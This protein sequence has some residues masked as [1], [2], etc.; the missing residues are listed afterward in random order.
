MQRTAISNSGKRCI[1]LFSVLIVV[2]VMGVGCSSS[3]GDDPAPGGTGTPSEAVDNTRFY[4]T[5]DTTMQVG[6]CPPEQFTATVGNDQSRQNQ[7]GYVYI[8]QSKNSESFINSDGDR[9]T[10]TVTGNTVHM[11][12]TGSDWTFDLTLQYA[13]DDDTITLS[14]NAT[15]NDPAECQGAIS[16]NA[17]RAS[18][19]PAPGPGPSTTLFDL[20]PGKT[21]TYSVRDLTNSAISWTSTIVVQN[22]EIINGITYDQVQITN[23]YGEN[24]VRLLSVRSTE[25]EFYILDGNTE[26]LWFRTGDVGYEF[27][28]DPGGDNDPVEITA[29]GNISLPY[30]AVT[31]Y[32]FSVSDTDGSAPYLI[33]SI[34]PG[35]GI[36]K[37]IDYKRNTLMELVS[38]SN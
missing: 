26:R 19:S 27:V 30:G 24:E 36:V 20:S 37:Q 25:N 5:F 16:G 15:E 23:Q 17:T 22:P 11:E 29:Y 32:E 3:S 31:A 13:E 18:A 28:R 35:L 34:S 33:Q 9:V 38:V 7:E 21:S 1:A 2:V 4:G 14:G 10:V 6:T 8:P 12:I